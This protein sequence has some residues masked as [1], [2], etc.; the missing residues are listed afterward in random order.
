L[1]ERADKRRLRIEIVERILTMDAADR[2]GQEHAL[3][4]RLRTLPGFAEAHTVL[5]Y[6]S[7]FPEEID[8]TAMLGGCLA[9]GKRLVCPRVDRKASVLRL[10]QIKH[11]R[12]DLAP[13]ALGIPE[14]KRS[15]TPVDPAEV[16]WMLAPGLAFDSR[17]F[18]LGRGAGYYDR[19]LP[20]LRA[21]TPRFAF[22]LEPQWVEALPV[23]PH[24]QQLDA[25]VSRT[26]SA[27]SARRKTQAD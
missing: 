8:T 24:D 21:D 27:T 20:T 15:C 6:V 18:R 23:E 10:Y 13:G 22:A 7:A 9:S 25:V 5:L 16:D 17:C 12:E 1:D 2:A 19:L 4:E 26:R 14:P 11:L 3:A